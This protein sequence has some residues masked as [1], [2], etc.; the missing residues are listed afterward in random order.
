MN[1]MTPVLAAL[2]LGLSMMPALA[3]PATS[4]P[5]EQFR[6]GTPV[7]QVQCSDSKILMESSRGTPVCVSEASAKRLE[8]RGWVTLLQTDGTV[9]RNQPAEAKNMQE[10]PDMPE[11]N[12]NVGDD[13]IFEAE[14]MQE[15]PDMQNQTGADEEPVYAICKVHINLCT[16]FNR[17]EPGEEPAYVMGSK[18]V[19]ELIPQDITYPPAVKLPP[20]DPDAFAEKIVSFTGDKIVEKRVSHNKISY[21]TETGHIFIYKYVDNRYRVSI[22]FGY[23]HQIKLNDAE[24]AAHD[25]LEHMGMNPQYMGNP[26]LEN[27]SHDYRHVYY[28]LLNGNTVSTNTFAANFYGG[29]TGFYFGYWNENLDEI[30]TVD[31]ATAKA[32]AI[33]YVLENDRYLNT[34]CKDNHE[35]RERGFFI[36]KM[37]LD[38]PVYKIEVTY[39]WIPPSIKGSSDDYVS[40]AYFA[41]IDAITGKPLFAEKQ[42]DAGHYYVNDETGKL[43]KKLYFR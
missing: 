7:E 2:A 11:T 29:F 24:Q 1:A 17:A 18:K 12:H 25:F 5:Y 42:G 19:S 32:T 28:Q 37:L 40:I 21:F 4:S 27:Y 16:T 13:Q 23:P 20:D 10:I 30:D 41:T 39:C 35:P 33:K 3:D 22:T 26:H 8:Q 38:R 36:T 14:N 15:L 43:E 6:A 31:M 34:G 9:P